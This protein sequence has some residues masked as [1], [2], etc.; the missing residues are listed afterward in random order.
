MQLKQHNS[1]GDY[2]IE[3][4]LFDLDDTL[5]PIVPVIQAA[6]RRLQAWLQQHVPAVAER[7]SIESLRARRAALLQE[8]PN[9]QIDFWALRHAG[10]TEAFIACDADESLVVQAMAVFSEARNAVT[11]FEDVIPALTRLGRRF[12]LG[13]ISNGY[14]DLQVIGLAAHFKISLAA[15]S[16]G[17]AKPDAS[18]FHA[19]CRALSVQPSQA[20]YVGD[21]FQLDVV[22]AQ[23]AGLQA[24]WINRFGRDV[25]PGVHPD[26]VCADLLGLEQLLN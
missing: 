20:L 7:W 22:G 10:L 15:H 3:A 5:W 21:D 11:P 9:F 17:H 4:I 16:F 14:A 25:P 26:F 13:S 12:K 2:R 18:I 8:N 1:G 23:N 24:V 19:A 6:E